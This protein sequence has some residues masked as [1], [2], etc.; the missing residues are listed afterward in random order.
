MVYEPGCFRES[1]NPRKPFTFEKLERSAPT[2][3]YVLDLVRH[4]SLFHRR[5][6]IAAAHDGNS[7]RIFRQ[8][9]RNGRSAGGEGRHLKDAHRPVPDDGAGARDFCGKQLDRRGAY[10]EPHPISREW[11][12]SSKI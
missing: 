8:R 9:F 5:Y 3:G 7:G 4:P 2:S 12:I 11:T 10:V 6:G 1:L